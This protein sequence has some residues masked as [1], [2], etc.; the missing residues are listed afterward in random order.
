MIKVQ[1]IDDNIGVTE[2]LS[3]V[4]NKEPDITVVNI[5]TDGKIGLDN[6]LKLHPD[7]LILDLDLP[8]MN[9]V[10]IL[11]TLCESPAEEE[12][13]N[14]V[15]VMTA[16]YEDF[17]FQCTTKLHSV[18]T[19]P[20]ELTDVIPKVRR[21][22]EKQIKTFTENEKAHYLAECRKTC[23]E[24]ILKLGLKP[25]FLNSLYLTDAVM[26]LL[27]SKKQVFTLKDI[28]KEIS[29]KHQI[30]PHRI[31]WCLDRAIR[32]LNCKCTFSKLKEV[33]PDYPEEQ[34]ITL[35]N[36]ICFIAMQIEPQNLYLEQFQ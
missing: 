1:I 11:N 12:S 17:I 31:R 4:L 15:I 25:K 13:G 27:E 20:F 10:E 18:L 26:V 19:K 33:L 3:T 29:V 2:S 8:T 6:Y 22:K 7:V 36:L 30:S 14:N 23:N 34:N 35:K 24:I 16:H 21:I 28:Y 32:T 5:S 9:G